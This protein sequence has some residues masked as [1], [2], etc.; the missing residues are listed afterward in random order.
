MF[1]DRYLRGDHERGAIGEREFHPGLVPGE[2]R[3]IW[4]RFRH[5]YQQRRRD[6]L[7]QHVGH[8]FGYLQRYSEFRNGSDAYCDS[9]F[10]LL[11]ICRLDRRL[12]G[13]GCML[14]HG[15]NGSGECDRNLLARTAEHV[16]AD[17]NRRGIGDG[18]KFSG[19]DLVRRNLF[20]ELSERHVGHADRS[21]YVRISV[22]RLERRNLRGHGQLRRHYEHEHLGDG[23]LRSTLLTGSDAFRIGLRHQ[24]PG[25][26]QLR[27][28]LF[29]DIRIRNCGQPHGN[30]CDW[31][32]LQ[33]LGRRLLG[34]G[35]V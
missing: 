27:H 2:R 26:H 6:Q 5:S 16:D 7:R 29:G 33:Q 34:Y 30:A 35:R 14:G 11:D 4:N 15:R 9:G 32:G 31:S 10:G 28:D 20:G 21:R 23:H 18:N 25:R 13:H 24:F 12:L 3:T 1:W 19:R 22:H 17:E 8:D